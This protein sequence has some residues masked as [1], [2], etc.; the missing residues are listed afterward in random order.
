MRR[1]IASVPQ[2]PSWIDIR[3]QCIY[4]IASL[5]DTRVGCEATAWPRGVRISCWLCSSRWGWWCTSP[6]SPGWTASSAGHRISTDHVDITAYVRGGPA[7]SFSLVLDIDPRE[8]IRVYAPDAVDSHAV[9]VTVAP[10]PFLQVQPPTFCGPTL[11][12][13]GPSGRNP[14]LSRS[15]RLDASGDPSG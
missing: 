13:N 4:S 1:R 11:P 8:R 5:V 15:A 2:H 3:T 12:F 6:L 10:T 14:T 7:G 9:T